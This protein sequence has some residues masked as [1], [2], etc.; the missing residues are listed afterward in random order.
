MNYSNI[1]IDIG[2]SRMKVLLGSNFYNY[3][4]QENDYLEFEK[5]ISKLSGNNRIFYSS[6]NL[7]AQKDLL[8]IYRKYKISAI[9]IKEILSIQEIIDI[10]QV[11]GAGSDRILG[12]I[13]ASE[14]NNRTFTT[15]DFGSATTINFVENNKFIGGSIMPGGNT[16][17]K[18]LGLISKK[19]EFDEIT[20]FENA[21]GKDTHAAIN[22]GIYLATIGGIEFALKNINSIDS[23]LT[24]SIFVTGGLSSIFFPKLYDKYNII[25][26]PNL[27]IEGMKKLINQYLWEYN[28]F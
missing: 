6:V 26:K 4:Y 13:G 14:I 24:N 21:I 9:N 17:L 2:N 3:F 16:L 1:F 27:V 18:A 5:L 10:N 28:F 11:S 22:N 23:K 7:K 20:E 19:L 15:I 8:K 25:H 12:L